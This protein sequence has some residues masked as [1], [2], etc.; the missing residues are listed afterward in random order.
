MELRGDAGLVN[1]R[2][3]ILKMVTFDKVGFGRIKMGL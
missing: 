1:L 3:Y 2:L